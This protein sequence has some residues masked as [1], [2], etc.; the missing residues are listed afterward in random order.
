MEQ[1]QLLGH[2]VLINKELTQTLYKELPLLS[3]KGHCGCSDCR[4]YVK[5][6]ETLD[7]QVR[8][9]DQFG[10]DPRREGEIWHVYENDDGVHYY[11]GFYHF[12]GEIVGI[13][14]L[15][16]IGVGNFKFGLTNASKDSALVPDS[17]L[18]PIIELSIKAYL[19]WDVEY[20]ENYHLHLGYYE[21]NC[22][23]EC[24]AF[25]RKMEDVWDVFFDFE[26]YGLQNLIPENA[27]SV[28]GYRKP[29]F[30]IYTK[31]IDYVWGAEQFE[32]MVVIA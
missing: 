12:V 2:T 30:F 6:C 8:I 13:D 11:D 7:E 27:L 10:V 24:V 31:K 4:N 5:A 16:W 17:F 1:V 32:Q 23:F 20:D 15:D 18:N 3:D 21:N 19:S 28:D 26:Q 22:D 14:E 29:R 9:F 25:K